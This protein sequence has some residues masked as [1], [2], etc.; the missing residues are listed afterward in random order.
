MSES[1]PAAF[2]Q[3]GIVEVMGHKRFA[4]HIT[5]QVIAG[6]ALVRVDV[7]SV[8]VVAPSYPDRTIPEY[9]K[10]IG[11]GSIYMITPT[12][13]EVAR[14]AAAQIARHDSDPLPVY[15]PPERQL[16]AAPDVADADVDDDFDNVNDDDGEDLG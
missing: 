6:A 14:K 9:S 16:A 10:L 12:S 11:V 3:W 7:P 13:E 4:G 2:D 1:N 8:V 5:E 15:I